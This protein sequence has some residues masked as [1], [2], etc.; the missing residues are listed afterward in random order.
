MCSYG[1]DE[2]CRGWINDGDLKSRENQFILNETCLESG[3]TIGL[4]FSSCNEIKSDK[5][6]ARVLIDDWD[7]Q[8]ERGGIIFKG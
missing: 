4:V 8:G 7:V 5:F 1:L 3:S 6:F 2:K